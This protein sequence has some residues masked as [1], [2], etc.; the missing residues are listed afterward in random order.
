MKHLAD[1]RSGSTVA[2]VAQFLRLARADNDKSWAQ[3]W[4]KPVQQPANNRRVVEFI[5]I[6][7]GREV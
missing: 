4:Q 1:H 7:R 6:A 5:R 3:V 2:R